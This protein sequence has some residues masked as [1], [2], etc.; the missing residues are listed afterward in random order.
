MGSNMF[1]G[2][3][4]Y[5]VWTT[6]VVALT[7]AAPMALSQSDYPSRPITIVVPTQAGGGL[8][9]V[10][11]M[12]ADGLSKQLGKSVVVENR[13]G[14]GTLVGTQYVAAAQPDGYTLLLGG[15]PN[16]VFNSA[17]YKTPKYDP[18]TDFVSL[19]MVATYP[20][21][22]LARADLPAQSY[23]NL[24]DLIKAQP[25]GLTIATAGPGTAQHILAAAFIKATGARIT[26]VPYKG[27][28][29]AYQDILGGRVDMFIDAWPSARGQL[30]GKRVK[31]IFT[32]GPSRLPDLPDVP[33]TRELGL[34]TV[35][36]E[37]WISIV[38][39]AKTPTVTV[40]LLR[41]SLVSMTNTPEWKTRIEKSGMQELR[42]SIPVAEKY[43]AG[44]FEKWTS[45]IRQ[46]Q[47]NAE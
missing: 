23:K 45:F 21:L 35:E 9:L 41:S 39:P 31:P 26:L 19:G 10:G 11:R 12:V 46:S 36:N 20:Y 13:V 6:A 8:D 28:V 33:T 16:L 7:S 4:K 17:L 24:F 43:I 29:S 40:E 25:D 1:K 27:A 3:M 15:Q 14:S 38:A 22:L 30:A 5:T 44:D 2:F 37:S 18:R 34:P 42:M 47:I 32:T